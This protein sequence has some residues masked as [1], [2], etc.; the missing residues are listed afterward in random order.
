M[1]ED[2]VDTDRELIAHGISN[3]ASGMLG[4]V[5]NYLCYVNS[6]LF[7]KVGGDTRLS[8]FLLAL[9]TAGVL[10]VGPG[11]IGYLPVSVVGA[12]IFILGLDLVKEV[13]PIAPLVARPLMKIMQAVWDTHGRVARFEYITIWSIIITMTVFDF[14]MGIGVGILLACVSF[15]VSS[16]QRKAIRSVLSGAVARS[17]VR[18]HPKQ[19]AFLKEV[20]RQ[21]RV[22]KLSGFLFFG[23]ESF[24]IVYFLGHY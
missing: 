12:L 24:F 2:D 4:T 11:V 21:T 8:G 5:P 22:I 18:R 17:T 20:G 9:A 13:S 10:V 7:Y 6:V 1:G 14:V 16:S 3:I 23:S 15:V 19:S